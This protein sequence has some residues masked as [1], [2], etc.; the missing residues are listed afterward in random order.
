[1]ASG[2]IQFAFVLASGIINIMP[3]EVGAGQKQRSRVSSKY[4]YP[5]F[6]TVE[7][8]RI[9]RY[10]AVLHKQYKA[11]RNYTDYEA[12]ALC[13]T[14]VKKLIKLAQ[15]QHT[16]K[17]QNQLQI[18]PNSFWNYVKSRRDPKKDTVGEEVE[19]TAAHSLMAASNNGEKRVNPNMNLHRQWSQT[20]KQIS[21]QTGG[22]CP[23]IGPDLG[24]LHKPVDKATAGGNFT[25]I[26]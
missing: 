12:F 6:Y 17:V 21:K 19:P 8:I 9:I 24:I 2:L 4:V 25:G 7:I 23:L 10:K 1:M 26:V 14:K 5:E 16:N 18:D 11:S 22:R 15:E 13:R 3:N 20:K